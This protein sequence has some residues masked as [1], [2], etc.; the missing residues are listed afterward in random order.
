MANRRTVISQI[1]LGFAALLA[2]SA[3]TSGAAAP[4][5]PDPLTMQGA[6]ADDLV[7]RLGPPQAQQSLGNGRTVLQ[8][9]WS[10]S[11]MAG[12]FTTTPDGQLYT[13]STWNLPRSYV[14]EQRVTQT[15]IVQFTLGPDQRVQEVHTQ[16]DGC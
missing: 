14:P 11:Y 10:S 8:Y 16:G 9:D 1:A 6:S 7:R 2:L 5:H 3:C 12:G 15:C 4:N 13:G